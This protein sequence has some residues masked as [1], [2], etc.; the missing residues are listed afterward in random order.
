MIQIK[1]DL[2]QYEKKW[3][4]L[5]NAQNAIDSL[6]DEIEKDMPILLER[7]ESVKAEIKK[8]RAFLIKLDKFIAEEPIWHSLL[9]WIGPI[10]KRKYAALRY[11]LSNNCPE[12]IKIRD[13]LETN[14]QDV[15]A[16]VES[17][18]KEKE[19]KLKK[20]QSKL[21]EYEKAIQEHQMAKSEWAEIFGN[22]SIKD[23]EE[24]IDTTIRFEL[25]H[26]ASH[27]WEARWLK[28]MQEIQD[29]AKEKQQK[30]KNAVTRRWRRRMMLTPCAVST[31]FMLPHE[32]K[33]RCHDGETFRDDYLYNLIDLL[34][35]DEAGQ[36]SPEVAGA[37]FALAKKALVIGD[38]L[39]IEPIW[40]IPKHVDIGNMKSC[41]GCP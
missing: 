29:P 4:R 2:I 25:F 11:F 8:A 5:K 34:I 16:N 3:L 35:V 12:H 30:G 9:A 7:V 14:A 24:K 15:R 17:L 28:E 38:T 27:Y 6:K 40:S 10:K 31:F 39:Q 13:G 37:S 33:V 32:M 36:V 21:L 19:A 18:L 20:D 22:L 1:E 23:V 26:L 41:G